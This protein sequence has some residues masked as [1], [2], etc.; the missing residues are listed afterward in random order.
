MTAMYGTFSLRNCLGKASF[1]ETTTV[2]MSASM[3][4]YQAKALLTIVPVQNK[5]P[6]P[7]E[8]SGKGWPP[9]EPNLAANI[10]EDYVRLHLGGGDRK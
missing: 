8:N 3:G 7:L 2:E 5:H 10:M 6:W 4:P 1:D 9:S